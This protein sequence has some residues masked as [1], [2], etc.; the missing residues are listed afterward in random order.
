MV[1]LLGQQ[2]AIELPALREGRI[3]AD[4]GLE[5]QRV[6]ALMQRQR[7]VVNPHHRIVD[8]VPLHSDGQVWIAEIGIHHIG[9]CSAVLSLAVFYDAQELA[10]ALVGVAVEHLHGKQVV[11]RG[12]D[13]GVKNNKGNTG[14]LLS[15]GR[16]RGRIVIVA[17]SSKGEA[18][19]DGD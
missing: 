5:H 13:V 9:H 10:L 4:A 6:A 19:T 17:T 16:I 11:G 1:G 3:V 12:A 2:P 7:S 15:V 8:T 18:H 14:V